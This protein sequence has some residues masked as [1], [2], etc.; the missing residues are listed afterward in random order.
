MKITKI[1]VP[2]VA[3][4]VLIGLLIPVV[5]TWIAATFPGSAFVWSPLVVA[6]LG[7]ILKWISWV[8][9]E[10]KQPLPTEGE[11]P[12]FPVSAVYVGDDDFG[13]PMIDYVPDQ[14]FDVIDFL[15]GVKRG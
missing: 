15:F 6:V 13:Q 2:A 5:Q 7:A 3:W 12:P 9:Q 10:N 8:M 1:E 4:W 11:Q 14:H